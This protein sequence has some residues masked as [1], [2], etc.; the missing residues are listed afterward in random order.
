MWPL[1]RRFAVAAVGGEGP[2]PE[3]VPASGAFVYVWFAAI[4]GC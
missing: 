4:N 2:S 3:V 1:A